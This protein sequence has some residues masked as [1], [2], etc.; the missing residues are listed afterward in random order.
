MA[1]PTIEKVDF[2]KLSPRDTGILV[3]C[4]LAVLGYG[5]H[6]FE[7]LKLQGKK[8]SA[9]TKLSQAENMIAAFQQAIVSPEQI[10]KTEADIVTVGKEMEGINAEIGNIKDRMSAKSVTILQ[11]LKKEAG[12]KGGVLRSFKTA[13]KKISKG[14]YTYKEIGITM[15][16]QSEYQT[17]T[18]LIKK[19]QDVPEFLALKSLETERV[20]DILP[21]VETLL[22]FELV[23]F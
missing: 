1:A 7:Y 10:R 16:I 4:V 22:Q 21:L 5:W 9:E 14:Q 20:E 6:K 3:F 12:S 13:E 11:Q 19:F 23:V 18:G 8:T 17:I 15:K 2:N